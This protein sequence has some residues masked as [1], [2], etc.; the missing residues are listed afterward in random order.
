MVLPFAAAQ[1]TAAAA[2]GVVA[3]GIIFV[4]IWIVFIVAIFIL[5]IGLLLLWVFMLIDAVKRKNWK[6][7]NERIVW[8]LI[9][10]LLGGLG[11]VVYYFAV[12][13]LRGPA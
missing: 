12:R 11:A 7:D 2:G 6:D 4:V 1:D 3:V 9:V 8:L 13:H 10:A 5:T